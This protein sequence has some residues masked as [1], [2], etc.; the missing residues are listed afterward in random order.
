M[1]AEDWNERS[2]GSG[3]IAY[4]TWVPGMGELSW[5][6]GRWKEEISSSVDV[7]E[8]YHKGQEWTGLERRSSGHRRWWVFLDRV[9]KYAGITRNIGCICTR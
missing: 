9:S 8:K 4:I 5:S 2:G 3:T 7:N 1:R 6:G